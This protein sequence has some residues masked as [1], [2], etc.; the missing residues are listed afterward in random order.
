MTDPRIIVAL[1]FDSA[2]TALALADR[3]EP[4]QC[5]LKV[6]KELFTCAGP[7]LVEDLQARGFDVFLDLKFH[8][9]PNTVAKACRAAADLGVWMV[10][11]HTLGGR[12]MMEAAREAVDAASY[13]PLL[14]GVTI[15]TS[16]G[17]DDLREVGLSG[18][19]EHNV[20]RLACLAEASGLDGV[21]CSP[22]EVSVL[23]DTVGHAFRLVTPGVRPA[24]SISD[25]Q[26]RVTTPEDA[27]ANGSHYLVVGRPI[28]RAEDPV[29]ALRAINAVILPRL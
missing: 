3:L 18:S 7:A 11:V 10:N 12:R 25:D 9:I 16:M 24:D 27:I 20:L 19:P 4:G 15:L 26:K 29:A 8:D 17:V 22:R 21:V 1:D 28:T 23:R 5:R 14:I 2:K 13:N 6:G